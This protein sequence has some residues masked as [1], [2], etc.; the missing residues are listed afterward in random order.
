MSKTKTTS[1]NK[2][3]KK[4][5]KKAEGG[6]KKRKFHPGTVA[7]RQIRKLQ[8]STK[9]L[10]RKAPFSRM[11]RELA[12]GHKEGLRW[13]ASAV[14]AMQEA[15]EGYAVGLLSDANLCALHSK[16]V[17]CQVKDVHLARR[18]RGERN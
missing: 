9:V 13:Q 12:S 7:L 16:R 1:V 10:M 11:I 2:S 5:A 14:A 3:S 6:K 18:L 17:T 8:K 15:T 4:A